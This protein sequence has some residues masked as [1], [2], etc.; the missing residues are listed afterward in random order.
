MC[1]QPEPQGCLTHVAVSSCRSL[2]MR[3]SGPETVMMPQVHG[4]RAP[5]YYPLHRHNMSKL[6]LNDNAEREECAKIAA[7]R[8]SDWWGGRRHKTPAETR[9]TSGRLSVSVPLS[10][11]PAVPLPRLGRRCLANPIKT[12][13][14]RVLASP[15]QVFASEEAPSYEVQKQQAPIHIPGKKK[16]NSPE[17]RLHQVLRQRNG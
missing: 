13:S 2:G 9:D 17:S 10:G 14:R 15:S 16:K 11:R 6:C 7:G 4:A 5:C 3:K 12:L 8:C 1:Q